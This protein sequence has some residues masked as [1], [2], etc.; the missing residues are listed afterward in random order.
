MGMIL[1]AKSAL[2]REHTFH[3]RFFLSVYLYLV[4]DSDI[5]LPGNHRSVVLYTV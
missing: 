5:T 3:E 1:K 4:R 2:R